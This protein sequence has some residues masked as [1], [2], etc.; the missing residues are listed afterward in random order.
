MQRLYW[1]KEDIT[2]DILLREVWALLCNDCTWLLLE[3]DT[4]IGTQRGPQKEATYF[5]Y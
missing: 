5:R 4:S 2:E 3:L 1:G